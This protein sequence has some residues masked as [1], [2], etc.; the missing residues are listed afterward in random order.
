M[1]LIL[2][3]IVSA[4]VIAAVA[5]IAKRSTVFGALVA[6]LPL[7]SVLAMIW[8]YQDTKDT[9]RVAALSANIFWLVLPSL[10]LFI[11]LPMLLKRGFSFYAA[12]GLACSCTVVA[13]AG[14]AILMPRFGVKI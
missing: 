13:Y 3:I 10:L 14:M 8:L 1:P 5:E 11:V 12:L 6:S 9:A 2:K 7:T 4:L